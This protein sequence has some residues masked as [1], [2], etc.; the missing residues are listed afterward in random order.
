MFYVFII[1]PDN[2]HICFDIPAEQVDCEFKD[3]NV[4]L[5]WHQK[6]FC[7][8][9]LYS[10]IKNVNTCGHIPGHPLKCEGHEFQLTAK[11]NNNNNNY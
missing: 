8:H 4:S 9:G 1:C 11:R 10:T 3:I 2:W 5:L 7:S 6:C